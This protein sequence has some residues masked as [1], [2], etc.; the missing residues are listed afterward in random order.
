MLVASALLLLG[1]VGV[2]VYFAYNF[3]QQQPSAKH[4]P[5]QAGVLAAETSPAEAP[6]SSQPALGFDLSTITDFGPSEGTTAEQWTRLQSL[7][8][9]YLDFSDAAR[10][11]AAG[12][13]LELTPRQS[14]PA[15]LNQFKKLKLEQNDGF[16]AA[17]MAAQLLERICHGNKVGWKQEHDED[18][19]QFDQQA[20]KKWCD[21]WTKASTDEV[22]W[23]NLIR[24]GAADAKESAG[25]AAPVKK[26][27]GV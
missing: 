1:V 8:A 16:R 6:A 23:N 19:V 22:A 26:T 21:L 10:S 9:T 15:V 2:G 3:F 24:N 18:Y 25:G 5:K 13:Q 17:E 27:G 14:F 20:I 12:T 11:S 7:A 4:E